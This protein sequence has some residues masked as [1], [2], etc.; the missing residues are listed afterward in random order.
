[1][2][3]LETELNHEFILHLRHDVGV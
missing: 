2:K 1:M 3:V